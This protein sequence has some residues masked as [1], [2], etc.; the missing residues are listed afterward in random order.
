M[1]S[2]RV[3]GG[4]LEVA[5]GE[6]HRPA[7]VITTDTPALAAVLWHGRNAGEAMAAGEWTVEG[8]PAAAA[9]LAALFAAPV[10]VAAP[11]VDF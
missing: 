1:F 5:R 8:D 11:A 9:R 10:P 2:L 7:A 3:D 4:G 6:A